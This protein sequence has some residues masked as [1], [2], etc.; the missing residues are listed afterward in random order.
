MAGSDPSAHTVSLL[1]SS[2]QISGALFPPKSATAFHCDRGS[3]DFV[4]S[5]RAR[6]FRRECFCFRS[7]V[8]PDGITM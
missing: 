5:E 3:C 4:Q 1:P 6:V 7:A 8:L 2:V